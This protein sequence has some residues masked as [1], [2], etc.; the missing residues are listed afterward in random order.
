[1]PLRVDVQ[2]DTREQRAS[3]LAHRHGQLGLRQHFSHWAVSLHTAIIHHHQ[4]VGQA[5]HFIN[6]VGDV[7]HGDV[8]VVTQF[9]EPRQHFLFAR[10]VERGQG[11]VKQQQTRLRH[12]G[13]CNRHA[14]TL[15]T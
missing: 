13:A 12:Q 9:F 3:I 10:V 8:Q 6:R 5:G 14:L 2:H 1:M 7:K 15:A 4:C 11:F